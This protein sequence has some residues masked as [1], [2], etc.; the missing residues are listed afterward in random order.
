MTGRTVYFQ[1]KLHCS[2]AV[3]Y[4]F[5]EMAENAQMVH[6]VIFSKLVKELVDL[7]ED[8]KKTILDRY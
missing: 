2:N 1:T 5:L 8:V 3:E 7:S 4:I 6:N